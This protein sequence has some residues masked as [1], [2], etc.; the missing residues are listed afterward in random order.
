ML[1]TGSTLISLLKS[2]CGESPPPPHFGPRRFVARLV[3]KQPSEQKSSDLEERGGMYFNICSSS[4]G[5]SRIFVY[6]IR[7]TSGATQIT[8][9]R[10]KWSP[11]GTKMEATSIKNE[12]PGGSGRRCGAR[13]A[14][15]GQ[16][17]DPRSI[18]G[19][20]LAPFWEP[21]G[22]QKGSKWGPKSYQNLGSILKS[23][24]TEKGGQGGP[25]GPQMEPKWSQ[26]RSQEASKSKLVI[27]EKTMFYI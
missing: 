27:F 17:S 25:R 1:P 16:K 13:S 10:A 11:K 5:R 4:S 6:A 21:N 14:A 22:S 18:R 26:S 3:E 9:N 23:I 12:V 7:G 19:W 20:L 2:P 24:W 15:E 8:K